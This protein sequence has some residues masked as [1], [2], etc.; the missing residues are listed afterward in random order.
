M[1]EDRTHLRKV[2]GAQ[3]TL[4][5]NLN[6]SAI[7]EKLGL[8]RG[9]RELREHPSDDIHLLGEPAAVGGR[10]GSW[11]AIRRSCRGRTRGVTLEEPPQHEIADKH[12][13]CDLRY[14][15]GFVLRHGFW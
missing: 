3:D 9:S 6:V 10:N 11:P 1:A 13:R 14:T 4:G 12:A 8:N 5:R 7:P 2:A 15:G